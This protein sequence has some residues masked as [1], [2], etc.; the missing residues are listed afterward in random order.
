MS[1]N[2]HNITIV[3]GGFAGIKAALE[4]VKDDRFRI[5][6]IS[7]NT[8]F[9]I[10]GTLYR[11]ATGGTKRISAIPLTH[12]FKDKPIHLIHDK[13]VSIDRDKRTV[14]TQIGHTINYDALLMGIGVTTNYFG[15]KGLEEYSFGIKSVD[16]AEELKQHLHQQLIDNK[17]LDLNYVVVGG[18]PT[19]V[20]LAGVLPSYIK[21]I[22]KRH[23][24]PGKHKVHVD[25][26]EAAPRLLPRMPKDLSIAVARHLRSIGVKVRVKTS[27]QAQTADALMVNNK[28]IRSH[29]VIWT[30]GVTNNPLFKKEGFQLSKNGRVRVDHFLQ[31]EPGIYV[32]GDNADTP[33]CGMAQTALHDGRYV[34]RNLIRI[35]NGEEPEPY[36]AKKP[37]Y[38]MPAGPK[39]AAVLWGRFRIYGRVGWWLRRMA[40]LIAYH[41]YRP[42]FNAVELFLSEQDEEESCVICADDLSKAKYLS[43]S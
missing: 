7:D 8:D 42:L 28:P 29:T 24:I 17:K 15:I 21:H 40:D 1:K 2:K 23:N 9:H 35:A 39:W 26:I 4:L 43:A 37:I 31:A 32:L 36:K 12:I 34:A 22:A 11:T 25:L 16:Q 33:Y 13:V 5:T 10:Y 6:L 27:V 3:G 38:V 41:D 14:K 19:G 20:E 30:A 18:G